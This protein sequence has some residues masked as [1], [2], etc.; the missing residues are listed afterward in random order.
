MRRG[1]AHGQ[2]INLFCGIAKADTLKGQ[3]DRNVPLHPSVSSSDIPCS[4]TV[5]QFNSSLPVGSV[6]SN[7]YESS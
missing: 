7:T 1:R 3:P 2:T 5:D 4:A 6:L